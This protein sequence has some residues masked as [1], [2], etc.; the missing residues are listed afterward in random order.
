MNSHKWS[1]ARTGKCELNS[2]L[3]QTNY[4]LIINCSSL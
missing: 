2:C 4:E 1:A 3:G